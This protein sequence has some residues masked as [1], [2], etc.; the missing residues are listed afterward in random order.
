MP[1]EALHYFLVLDIQDTVCL[2]KHNIFNIWC[3]GYKVILRSVFLE[4]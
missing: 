2:G 1:G 4:K 3:I